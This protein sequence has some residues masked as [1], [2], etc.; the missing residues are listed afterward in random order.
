[1]ELGIIEDYSTFRYDE[2]WIS[3]SL[4]VRSAGESST[5]QYDAGVKLQ[6]QRAEVSD[7]AN[8]RARHHHD[9]TYKK[10]FETTSM[11]LEFVQTFVDEEWVH[12]IT[13]DQI[14]PVPTEF[15]TEDLT[16]RRSDL[17]FEINHRDGTI[18]LDIMIELQSSVDNLMAVRLLQYANLRLSQFL[19]RANP[20]EKRLKAFRIPHIVPILLYN[21]ESKWT[22]ATELRS[23]T[24][25]QKS[26]YG[27]DMK[28]CLIDVNRLQESE[29]VALGNAISAIFLLDQP[30]AQHNIAER[31]KIIF[32]EIM[33][34]IPRAH[35]E[36]VM[37]WISGKFPE[38]RPYVEKMR[39]NLER[40]ANIMSG[41][42]LWAEG[43]M[44]KGRTEGIEE[45]VLNMIVN[46]LVLDDVV[47]ISGLSSERVEELHR[48]VQEKKLQ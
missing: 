26:V 4:L 14:K 33:P 41:I 36:C 12:D 21:G 34:N 16:S 47:R 23:I 45:I 44:N 32:E 37:G 1:M 35:Q 10:L 29:L 39:E 24:T 11:V 8:E 43:L 7:T 5:T 2:E 17:I 20:N 3:Q 9:L 18:L 38:D 42:E 46:G 25:Y 28:Y 19:K 22:A 15:V 27:P 48:E 40:G 13:V 30:K 31:L 6:E